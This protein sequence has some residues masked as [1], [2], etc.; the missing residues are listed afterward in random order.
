MDRA[1]GSDRV[2]G[3]SSP[4]RATTRSMIGQGSP[5]RNKWKTW[6]VLSA[7]MDQV[8]DGDPAK[9]IAIAEFEDFFYGLG[10]GITLDSRG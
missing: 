7:F 2:K 1:P 6:S 5:T 9:K 4:P 3:G 8:F 10:D